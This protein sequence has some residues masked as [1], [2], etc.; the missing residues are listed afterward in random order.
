MGVDGERD[1]FEA[2][3]HFQR[4]RKGGRELRYIGAAA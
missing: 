3:A 1:V 2:R 4:Q